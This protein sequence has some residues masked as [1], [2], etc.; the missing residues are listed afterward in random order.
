MVYGAVVLVVMNVTLVDAYWQAFFS[1]QE[2]G[3]G[4][5]HHLLSVPAQYPKQ[6]D[7][8]SGTYWA[9]RHEVK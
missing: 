9:T 7:H 4:K 3:D 2:S 5:V 8:P 1:L 6:G